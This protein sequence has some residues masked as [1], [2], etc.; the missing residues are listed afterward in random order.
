MVIERFPPERLEAIYARFH[1]KGRGLPD[2]LRYVD[3]WLADS[4][5]TVWQIMETD[6]PTTFDKWTPYWDDLVDF[7]IRPLRSKPTGE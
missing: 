1:E 3:S 5:D 7:E 4:N 2:G 6:D